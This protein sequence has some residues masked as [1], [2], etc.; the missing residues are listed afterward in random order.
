M[1]S[2]L[3]PRTYSGYKRKL[4]I[5]MLNYLW[6]AM[7]LIGII[8]A[9]FSGTLNQVSE[10]IV[11]SAKEGMDL[12]IL[13]A[14][15]ISMWN[16]LLY[17]AE[18]S[19]LTKKLTKLM[20]PFLKYVFPDIPTEH[21]AND[22]IAENFIANMLGLSWACTPA[23]LKAMSALQSLRKEQGFDT[24]V[25]SDEMCTFLLLNISSLQLIPMN[26]IAYRSQ[27]GSVNPTAIV[28]P[29]LLATAITTLVTLCICR[30]IYRY[31]HK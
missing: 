22:Y 25:A 8:I 12:L 10:G 15:V 29:A 1:T 11:S 2:K 7:I 21:E 26:M 5:T 31:K 17:V 3:K 13:M 19:G 18:Q 24:L 30:C 6:A 27:Y 4:G 23:G 9:A 28:G 20:K 14:G 16:G